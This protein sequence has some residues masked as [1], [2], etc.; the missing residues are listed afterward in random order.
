[1]LQQHRLSDRQRENKVQSC[2]GMTDLLAC[3]LLL[4]LQLL[5]MSWKKQVVARFEPCI[6]SWEF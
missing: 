5:I 2:S 4:V 1:M 3:S 6:Q